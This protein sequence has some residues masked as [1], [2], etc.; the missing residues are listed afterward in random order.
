MFPNLQLARIPS[1]FR[2]RLILFSFLSVL[3]MVASASAQSSGDVL[4][5]N[6]TFGLGD[7]DGDGRIG[8]ADLGIL[9]SAVAAEGASGSLS[10]ACS[11][12][13]D[14]NFDGFLDSGDFQLLE[15][16][17]RAGSAVYLLPKV[18]E[19]CGVPAPLSVAP[20]ASPGQTIEFIVMSRWA[21]EGEEWA[22]TADD[23]A[24]GLPISANSSNGAARTFT[25]SVSSESGA[26]SHIYIHL[27]SATRHLV[28]P[29][30]IV[31]GPSDTST[32]ASGPGVSTG[33]V[34]EVVPEPAVSPSPAVSPVPT[35]SPAMTFLPA[36]TVSPEPTGLK[37][38]S[39][40]VEPAVLTFSTTHL[41]VATVTPGSTLVVSPVIESDPAFKATPK[42]TASFIP[43]DTPF[44][45]ITPVATA[46]PTPAAVSNCPA[47]RAGRGCYAF[48]ANFL[49]DWEY[50][51]NDPASGQRQRNQFA[52]LIAALGVNGTG[53]TIEK[54]AGWE[55]TTN[56]DHVVDFNNVRRTVRFLLRPR[57][58]QR[59]D[60]YFIQDRNGA[61]V[62]WSGDTNGRWVNP[63]PEILNAWSRDQD[64]FLN[65]LEGARNW[66]LNQIVIRK[67][68]SVFWYVGGHGEPP[69]SWAR[70]PDWRYGWWGTGLGSYFSRE[71]HIFSLHLILSAA[72]PCDY[73]Y[74]DDACYG[75]QSNLKYRADIAPRALRPQT[76]NGMFIASA[77]P[78]ALAQYWTT[79]NTALRAGLNA[80]RAAGKPAEFTS[81]IRDRHLPTDSPF[82]T[83][84]FDRGKNE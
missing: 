67:P 23:G 81:Y 31:T 55:Q 74:V 56:V 63:A 6:P 38:F 42:P 29:I 3:P 61:W 8:S 14:M 80:A 12:A 68:E 44:K 45:T 26:G 27:V 22:V 35:V 16:A 57:P 20:T 9:A 62:P 65:R 76:R 69:A 1:F 50:S 51:S 34:S 18:Y 71:R 39:T 32:N 17:V 83:F 36:S 78:T 47:T 40:K 70:H 58:P 15:Y 2:Q 79:V 46:T 7:L 37:P 59:W 48:V 10:L 66:A 77:T 19:N 21:G 5:R 43:I 52:G 64:E 82:E 33:S 28:M 53:C 84:D 11:V 54:F 4:L 13:G 60:G 30:R 41:P 72:E 73:T 24:R 75:G 25:L 49:M